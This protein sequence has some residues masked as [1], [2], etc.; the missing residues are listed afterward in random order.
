MRTVYMV[1]NAHI[2]PVWL[3]QWQE[4][5]HEVRATFRSAI[6]LMDQN[7]DFIFTCDSVA[8]LA[9]VERVD[10]GLFEAIRK[11]AREGR[12]AV[13]GGWWIEPDCNLPHGESL[14][15]QALYAQRY[16]YSRLGKTATVGCN[17]DPFGHP[18]T[19]PQLLVKAGISSYLFLR[20][21][22]VEKELPGEVFRWSTPDGS[23]VIGYR[24][25]YGYTSPGD[26][27]E[28]FLHHALECIP[29]GDD[30]VMVL[31]GVG[32]HGGGPT[33]RDLTTIEK[34]QGE[35][36]GL[37]LVLA[38]PEDYFSRVRDRS[39]L[40]EYVGD[41]QHHAVGCYSAHSG[42]KRWN[43]RAEHLL[44][45]AERWAA[46]AER[47]GGPAYPDAELARAWQYVLFNQFHDTLAGTA[48]AP[49]YDD[50]RDQYGYASSVAADVLNLSVQS[51]GSRVDLPAEE[52]T[53]P[54]L[55]ANP[56]PWPVTADVE[57]ELEATSTAEVSVVDEATGETVA[58]QRVRSLATVGGRHRRLVVA[59]DLPPLGYR[60][61][62]IRPAGGSAYAVPTGPSPAAVAA[63][64][65]GGGSGMPAPRPVTE[66]VA[67]ETERLRV[68][69]DPAT[70][71]LCSFVD[72]RTGV[73]MMPER[74][75][76]HAVVLADASDT[77]GHG[78]VRYDQREG[79]FRPSA[80]HV[81]EEGPV[82]TVVEIVS[83]YGASCLVEKLVLGAR[84]PWLEVRCAL[85]W[86]E[87]QKALK[88]RFPSG[89][90]GPELK[91]TFS[92]PYG[93]LD[94]PPTGTEEVTQAWVD[95]S[96]QAP[97]GRRVGWAVLNDGKYAYDVDGPEIGMTVAR[98]PVFA[99]H[100]PH[101]LEPD[102]T[103]HY[104]DQGWQEFNYAI[105][106]HEGRPG[107]EIVRLAEQFNET[108][109]AVPEHFHPGPLPPS[110]AFAGGPGAAAADVVL[111][112]IKRAEDGGATVVR[113]Y[114]ATGHPAMAVLPLPLWDRTIEASFAPGEIKTF[115]L[116][117]DASLPIRDVSLLE[118][119][120]HEPN[121][122]NIPPQEPPT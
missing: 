94:R 1:G 110:G 37:N 48:L 116:P 53:I 6:N 64:A 4:G 98:S 100:D 82:R 8:Y 33:R 69:I 103:Y 45:A 49:A 86:Q 104:L 99:W 70:G 21:E 115:L 5:L 7:D 43:R 85:N 13:V 111:S 57:F 60:V 80:V 52:G 26:G 22:P 50:A 36:N 107:A 102:V 28:R 2:D 15:R 16:L 51:V 121:G 93:R 122:A 114:E 44:L 117:D 67:L 61:Y 29:G 109:I 31:Y 72:K 75:G 41:L 91:A 96:G 10:P 62:R 73:E 59:A 42:I 106:P 74:P 120:A 101:E 35:D 66:R 3:W 30:E 27:L 95:V 68:E 58:S 108:P 118:W 25:P 65:V 19:L 55:L 84:A 113:A 39:D 17:V 20:P 12:F 32:N 112:V 105:V 97:D 56:V 89:M 81:V 54:Y 88:I 18:A 11:R 92:I 40:P 24:I 77:W 83:K 119:E 34:L 71:W 79:E 9:W 76:A 87:H 63:P 38:S 14:V 90:A 78:V 47:L 23:T 46:V